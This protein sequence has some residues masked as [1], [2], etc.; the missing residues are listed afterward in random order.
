MA[1]KKLQTEID[2]V[3]K[4]VG[5]GVET[6]ESIFD[7]IQTANNV[8][9]KE[10]YEQDLK[11]EIKKLQRL[12]DQ[13]KTWISS[14]EIKDK[15]ALVDNRKLIESQMERFKAIEKEMKT[16]AFSKEGLA[17]K[18]M[19]DP[20]EKEKNDACDWISNMVDE[21][22]R[23]IET[24]EFELE[25]LQ[26]G[27]RKGKKDHARQERVG[28]I[29]H[30]C[31]RNRHHINRLELM[32]R[33]LENDHLEPERVME[34][35]EDVQYYIE[36]NQEPD[37]EEDEFIYED[38]GLEDEEEMYNIRTDEYHAEAALKEK[39][40]EKLAKKAKDKDDDSPLL[41]SSAQVSSSKASPQAETKPSASSS[42]VKSS[43]TTPSIPSSTTFA[44]IPKTKEPAAASPSSA[45][46]PAAVPGLKYAQAA[47]AAAAAAAVGHEKKSD[48]SV[49]S[50][51]V[52]PPKIIDQAKPKSTDASSTSDSPSMLS[53]HFSGKSPLDLHVGQLPEMTE[54]RLP[55]S[56]ADLAS[57]F[58]A[59]KARAG[60]DD[61]L[62]T[63]QMLDASLQHVPDLI[64]SERPKI[65]QP[66]NPHPTPNYYPQQPL[67]IFEN[68]ALFEKFDMDALF[69]I[70]YYRQGTYQQYLAAKELKKH[71][72]RFH[73]KYLTWFQR[74]EEPK[75]ITEDYEQGTY[76]Y[77][78]YEGAWC[79]RKKTDFKFE[80]RFL[81]EA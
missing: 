32:L 10:K 69:Y 46:T 28:E 70:F 60:K 48:A 49:P 62:Y 17:K 38:L 7:K 24:V 30:L 77:F 22:S 31:E 27:S 39:E 23:Q 33:L 4:K 29:E 37:F 66:K 53:S 54:A 44:D 5:E 14:N 3:L 51:W 18:E 56:L 75:T 12:R 76:I 8:N 13:I 59:V 9:Q 41:S 57:S 52:E 36:C 45:S 1:M 58:E 73:K 55:S 74:H 61:K 81:E 20:K 6:F 16:K 15:R 35:K 63:H 80:Y 50:A 21:L 68:P 25:T 43:V 71:S 72:W 47:A 11:K 40:D 2:R 19:M 64:D 79:Q 67:G 78:D 65:Y 34:I 42:P 26:S